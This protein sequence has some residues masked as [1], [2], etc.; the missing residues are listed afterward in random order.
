MKLRS[1]ESGDVEPDGHR[2]LEVVPEAVG[3]GLPRVED[4]AEVDLVR[5]GAVDVP[6]PNS[7]ALDDPNVRHK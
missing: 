7:L 1:L 3:H 6:V 4:V 2:S 5:F